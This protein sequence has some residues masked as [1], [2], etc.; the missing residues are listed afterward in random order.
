MQ[1][2]ALNSQALHLPRHLKLVLLRSQASGS[3]S[4]GVTLK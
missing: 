3:G 1:P 4:L 2:V